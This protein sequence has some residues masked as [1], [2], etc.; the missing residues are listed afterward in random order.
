MPAI[1]RTA[2]EV[3]AMLDDGR[4]I[5]FLDVREIVPFGTGHP[6][7]VTHLALGH[8]ECEIAGLVPRRDTRVI[9]T[10]GG[11]GLSAVAA[12]RLAR[13]GY[14]N[15][16]VL[17]GGAPAWAAAGLA[18]FPEIEVPS[19]GFGDFVA[20]HARP[21]FIKP[22]ELERAIA[23]GEDWVLIDSRPRQEYQ[24]GNIPGSID[25]PAGQM[26]RCFDDLVRNLT[27][28]VVVNC[29]SRT[30]GILGGTSLVRAPRRRA[31]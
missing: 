12:H 7:L 26:L 31:C 15:V 4:D 20:H 11:E 8:I 27:T 14:T 19:K 13:L 6:L 1:T 17:A 3:A 9:I 30:R 16:A 18:L 10:D 25:A 21:T 28:K 22:H 29:M 5:A 23:S 2:A 24:A